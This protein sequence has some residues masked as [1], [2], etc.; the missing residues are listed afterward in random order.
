MQS[1]GMRGAALLA[2]GRDDGDLADGGADIR[3]QRDPTREHAVVVRNQNA[4]TVLIC[5]CLWCGHV[6]PT[7]MRPACRAKARAMRHVSVHDRK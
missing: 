4:Q 1:E 7:T 3:E 5:E 2:V 6:A